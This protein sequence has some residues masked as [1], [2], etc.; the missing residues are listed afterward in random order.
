MQRKSTIDSMVQW[1]EHFIVFKTQVKTIGG[2]GGKRQRE[3][4]HY[5]SS[6]SDQKCCPIK[7]QWNSHCLLFCKLII[8]LAKSCSPF[9]VLA[10]ASQLILT[11]LLCSNTAHNGKNRCAPKHPS[12]QEIFDLHPC[13][14]K[15][16]IPFYLPLLCILSKQLYSFWLAIRP[17]FNNSWAHVVRAKWREEDSAC[18]KPLAVGSTWKIIIQ[19]IY[20]P[21]AAG[22]L[23]SSSFPAYLRAHVIVGHAPSLPPWYYY[24]YCF[25]VS[26]W[27]MVTASYKQVLGE[28]KRC[29]L[30]WPGRC[31]GNNVALVLLSLSGIC[32]SPVPGNPAL[33][34]GFR[35]R[36]KGMACCANWGLAKAGMS[37]SIS[38]AWHLGRHR[39]LCAGLVAVGLAWVTLGV[40][41]LFVCCSGAIL[42]T[43]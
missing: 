19:L 42:Q 14:C 39:V 27:V 18:Q 21:W 28:K 22:A 43:S 37:L 15:V 20:G 12:L 10:W 4:S 11:S 9:W 25:S 7:W 40:F 5:V 3:G 34:R 6:L 35:G 26:K 38:V 17:C 16:F 29:E 31:T 13:L 23:P 32:S 1:S 8:Q 24:H 30:R 33:S 41:L 36:H 2:D